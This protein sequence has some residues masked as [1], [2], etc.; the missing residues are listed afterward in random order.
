MSGAL[1]GTPGGVI[2]TLSKPQSVATHSCPFTKGLKCSRGLDKYYEP[3][4][5]SL[6]FYERQTLRW[7]LAITG[8][9]VPLLNNS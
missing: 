7:A 4:K 3:V 5:Y 9:L 6:G 1:R 2:Q 8:R